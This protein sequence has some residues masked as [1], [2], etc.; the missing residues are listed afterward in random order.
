MAGIQCRGE[1]RAFKGSS[2]QS[3]AAARRQQRQARDFTLLALFHGNYYLHSYH[4]LNDP[5]HV[6]KRMKAAIAT[7][8]SLVPNP[9]RATSI[10]RAHEYAVFTEFTWFLRMVLFDEIGDLRLVFGQPVDPAA[11]Q[12]YS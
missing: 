2:D 4:L 7:A 11:H 9:Q 6:E 1:M 5:P 10:Q 12:F 8:R 3:L